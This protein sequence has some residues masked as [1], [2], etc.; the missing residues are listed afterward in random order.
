MAFVGAACVLFVVL[1]GV[2]AHQLTGGALVDL[3]GAAV[4][5]INVAAVCTGV[6]CLG[7]CCVGVAVTWR[8]PAR[9]RRPRSAVPLWDTTL[10]R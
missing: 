10:S 7:L 3:R 2:F 9:D 1:L 6:F 5:A 8:R 4:V